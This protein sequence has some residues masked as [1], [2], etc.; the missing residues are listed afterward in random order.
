MDGV[1]PSDMF[2]VIVAADTLNLQ[3][4]VNHL[5]SHL[6]ENEAKWLEEHFV[7]IH[8]TFFRFDG[9][10]EDHFQGTERIFKSSDFTSLSEEF[11]I[12]LGSTR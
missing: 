12:L 10:I 6:I 3:E 4:V 11:L 8:D 2:K 1:D 7:R 9:F 5:Q